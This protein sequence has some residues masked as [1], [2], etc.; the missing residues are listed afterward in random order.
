MSRRD[1]IRLIGHERTHDKKEKHIHQYMNACPHDA[2]HQFWIAS[3]L[4]ES[5]IRDIDIESD[6]ADL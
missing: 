3:H 6:Q 4:I 2:R 1:K 5:Q